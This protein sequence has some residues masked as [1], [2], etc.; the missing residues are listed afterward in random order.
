MEGINSYKDLRK[1]VKK[2][3]SEYAKFQDI[4]REIDEL[5]DKDKKNDLID[6]DVVNNVLSGELKKHLLDNK[7]VAMILFHEIRRID[8]SK[9]D[10]DVQN[11][12]NSFK[13]HL[14]T[15]AYSEN[16]QENEI[17]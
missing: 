9:L 4:V 12:V 1:E 16:K 10:Q 6:N 7:Q 11:S 5:K 17:R 14:S 2:E 8:I 15:Y 13:N 3:D